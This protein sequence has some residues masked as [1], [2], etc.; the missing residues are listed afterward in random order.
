M[1][2]PVVQAF[3]ALRVS[4]RIAIAQH[5]NVCMAQGSH[6]TNDNYAIRLLQHIEKEGMMRELEQCMRAFQ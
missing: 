2:S 5:L 6:E 3:L 4:G 1:N